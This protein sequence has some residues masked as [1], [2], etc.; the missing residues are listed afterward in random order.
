[1]C[2]SCVILKECSFDISKGDIIN[3]NYIITIYRCCCRNIY[4]K[5][6]IFSFSY[7][8]YKINIIFTFVEEAEA[9]YALFLETQSQ[10]VVEM[11][12]ESYKHL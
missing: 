4:N 1:M 8:S 2:K 11:G 5:Q 6:L 9:E 7:K 3:S 10:Q 12:L